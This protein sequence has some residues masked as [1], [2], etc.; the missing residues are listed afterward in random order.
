MQTAV[1]YHLHQI[2]SSRTTSQLQFS[3]QTRVRLSV[4]SISNPGLS[5][6]ARVA[7]HIGHLYTLVIADIFARYNRLANPNRPVQFVT[8]TDEHGLKIQ[9]AAHGISHD[10]QVFCDRLSVQFRVRLLTILQKFSNV[11]YNR[12]GRNW[13]KKRTFPPPGSSGQQKRLITMLPSMF[14]YALK[15]PHSPCCSLTLRSKRTS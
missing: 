6:D 1:F 7:P 11:T 5:I 9:R 4:T 15:F 3:I 14:G 13:R 2:T 12:L 10:P 8:G